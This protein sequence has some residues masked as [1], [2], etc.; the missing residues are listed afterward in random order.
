MTVKGQVTVPKEFRD[1]FGWKP[2]DEV[3]F[4]QEK[5]GVKIV[6][7]KLEARSCGGRPLPSGSGREPGVAGGGD[8]TLVAAD[9]TRH[10][11]QPFAELEAGG[12]LQG[13]SGAQTQLGVGGR[14]VGKQR[15][16]PPDDLAGQLDDVHRC[17]VV[18]QGG[19][20]PVAFGDRKGT[21]AAASRQCRCHFQLGGP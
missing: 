17:D 19:Q 16:A 12:E 7:A 10:H 18:P 11:S 21:L 5:D 1:A 20:H 6:R 13:V 3:A 15:D 4:V 2:G 9:E 8:Q 14:L